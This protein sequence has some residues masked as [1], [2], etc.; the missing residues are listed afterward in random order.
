M[1][2]TRKPQELRKNHSSFVHIR[3]W[4]QKPLKTRQAV[5]NRLPKIMNAKSIMSKDYRKFSQ[6]SLDASD[7]TTYFETLTTC[8]IF[9]LFHNMHMERVLVIAA[10]PGADNVEHS[11]AKFQ[12]S[13]FLARRY[14]GIQSLLAFR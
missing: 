7:T 1:L 3:S 5:S 12:E 8:E 11:V 9:G 4:L 13:R 2:F 14:H 6:F 10:R